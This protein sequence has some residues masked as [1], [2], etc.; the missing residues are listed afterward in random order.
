MRSFSSINQFSNK[1]KRVCL[2]N[3]F[4]EAKATPPYH[5]PLFFFLSF[6]PLFTLPCFPHRAAYLNLARG[7]VNGCVSSPSRNRKH[8]ITYPSTCLQIHVPQILGEN[9]IV[10][11]FFIEGWGGRIPVLLNNRPHVTCFRKMRHV[12]KNFDMMLPTPLRHVARCVSLDEYSCAECDHVTWISD[13]VV[14]GY[15]IS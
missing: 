9:P 14:D 7:F 11:G 13:L 8:K 5:I 12:A 2:R 1:L 6:F 3:F 15:N 10:D 4:R